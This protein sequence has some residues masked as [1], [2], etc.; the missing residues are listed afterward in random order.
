MVL[1]T[2]LLDTHVFLWLTEEQESLSK[3][4]REILDDQSAKLLLSAASLWEMSIKAGIG[5]LRS[6]PNTERLWKHALHELSISVLPVH[7][8]H[9]LGV[10]RLPPYHND[11]FDRLLVSQCMV[12]KIPILSSDKLMRKYPIEVIW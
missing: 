6:N 11:P 3:R 10:L 5:K 1:L 12:E 2:V 9:A 4:A 8:D 7:T